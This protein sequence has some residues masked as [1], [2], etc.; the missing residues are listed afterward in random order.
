MRTVTFIFEKK[1]HSNIYDS[2]LILIIRSQLTGKHNSI[3]TQASMTPVH[4]MNISRLRHTHCSCM[5]D[6]LHVYVSV[7]IP[8]AVRTSAMASYVPFSHS[9]NVNRGPSQYASH[10]AFSSTLKPHNPRQP[11]VFIRVIFCHVLAL[12]S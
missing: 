6:F 10:L 7:S 12:K 4:G 8:V 2:F 11:Q 9:R 3:S 1:Y 5:F